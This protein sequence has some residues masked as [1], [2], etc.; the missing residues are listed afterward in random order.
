LTPAIR[1][2]AVSDYSYC[3][4]LLPCNQ[5]YRGSTGDGRAQ[6]SQGAPGHPLGPPLK[7]INRASAPA[8]PGPRWGNL[9]RCQP[10]G[11]PPLPKNL[12]PTQSF[13]HRAHLAPVMLISFRRHCPQV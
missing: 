13:G 2:H 7:P 9:Q 6:L 5:F 4:T 8:T 10:L 3:I 12:T 1:C 11:S